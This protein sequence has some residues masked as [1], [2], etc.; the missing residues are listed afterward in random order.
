MIICQLS[1]EWITYPFAIFNGYTFEVVE[2]ISDS[3]PHSIMDVIF[4]PNLIHISKRSPGILFLWTIIMLIFP[5]FYQ[6]QYEWTICIVV[7]SDRDI[8]W[9]RI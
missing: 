6:M 9:S 8:V 7:H 5:Q 3:F 4:Y 2:W 1:V